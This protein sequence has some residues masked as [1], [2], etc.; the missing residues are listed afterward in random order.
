MC[1][2]PM[3]VQHGSG[4]TLSHVLHGQR[5][6]HL[7]RVSSRPTLLF[8]DDERCN[9]QHHTLLPDNANQ[10]WQSRCDD[11]TIEKRVHPAVKPCDCV[12]QRCIATVTGR[13]DSPFAFSSCSS[14]ML[15]QCAAAVLHT[16]VS[17]R[18]QQ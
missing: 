1:A 5:P 8:S 9:R 10:R 2:R 14:R 7:M 6:L 15:G 13:I 16:V 4:R 12:R 3:Y 11:A 17:V 18:I